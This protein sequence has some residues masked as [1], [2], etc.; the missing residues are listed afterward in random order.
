MRTLFKEVISGKTYS[1]LEDGT[2][3]PPLPDEEVAKR[4]ARTPLFEQELREHR[5]AGG[6]TDDSYLGG[7]PHFAD[8]M[9]EDYAK[10]VY[11]EWDRQGI[12]YT[13]RTN[14]NPFHASYRGDPAGIV[15]GRSGIKK[16]LE[17]LNQEPIVDPLSTA[18]RLAEDLIQ[19]CAA[20]FAADNPDEFAKMK[21]AE[22]REHMIEKHGRKK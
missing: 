6:E 15:D 8:V 10:E 19:E 5:V 14:Y 11:S 13:A 16:R 2:Y 9:G 17:V 4:A 22:V 21:P 12:P 3:D 18:P 7:L 20:N 1:R